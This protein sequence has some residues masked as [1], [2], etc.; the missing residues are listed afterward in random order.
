[1]DWVQKTLQPD[2]LNGVFWGFYRTPEGQ[3]DENAVARSVARC[4][5]HSRLVDST[6]ADRPFLLGDRLSLADIAVGTHLHRY[7]ELE[8]ERPDVPNVEAYYG[9]LQ[10][11]PAYRQ[12]IMVP[13][14]ELFGRLAF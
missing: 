3:R 5:D 6:M 8:I 10:E 14:E 13:F 9:R 11:R 7:L 12:S 2:F 1:M 4:A